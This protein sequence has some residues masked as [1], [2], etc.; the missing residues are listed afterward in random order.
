MY[1]AHNVTTFDHLSLPGSAMVVASRVE[2]SRVAEEAAT[3]LP[4]VHLLICFLYLLCLFGPRSSHS[5]QSPVTS[6]QSPVT[7]TSLS[8]AS[9]STTIASAFSLLPLLLLLLLD[10]VFPFIWSLLRYSFQHY[11]HSFPTS[12]HPQF[13]LVFPQS[14]C[15]ST[16]SLFYSHPRLLYPLHNRLQWLMIVFESPFSSSSTI[17]ALIPSHSTVNSTL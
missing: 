17:S 3:E 5:H 15:S 1:Y 7:V 10:L 4:A 14:S 16:S 6:H 13:T 9:T 2:S 12:R 11:T 8:S